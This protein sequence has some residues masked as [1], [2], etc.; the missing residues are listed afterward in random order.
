ML[1]AGRFS[2]SHI[3]AVAEAVR[4]AGGQVVADVDELWTL[5]RPQVTAAPEGSNL[6]ATPGQAHRLKR[7]HERNEKRQPPG[8]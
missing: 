1:L 8:H 5:P 4:E 6:C 7:N 2:E 3:R